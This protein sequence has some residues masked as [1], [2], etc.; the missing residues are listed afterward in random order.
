MEFILSTAIFYY[1]LITA[2]LIITLLSA[3]HALLYKRDPRAS[4]GWLAVIFMFPVFGYILYFLFG[5]NRI[6]T[7]ARILTGKIPITGFL[8][9]EPVSETVRLPHSLAILPQGCAE[10]ATIADSITGIPLTSGNRIDIL[11]NGDNAYPLMLDAIENAERSLFLS[12]YIFKTDSTGREFIERLSKA[13]ERGVD[14]KVIIDGIGEYYSFPF[15]GRLLKKR[16]IEYARYIPPALF[17]PSIHINLR[18]H[19]KIL[20]AD[21]KIAFTGG[22]NIGSYNLVNDHDNRKKVIDVHFRIDGPVVLQIE[23][24]FIEDW[25]FITGQDIEAEPYEDAYKEG[26]RCRVISEGP[27]EDFNKLATIITGAISSA[28]KRIMIMT[29][30]FLPNREMISALQTASLK[31]VEVSILLPEKNN[32][33]YVHWATRNMLWELLIRGVKVYYEPPPFVHT[34]LFVVDDSYA[35]IGTANMDARSL[36]LNFELAVEVYDMA[37]TGKI[38]GH[39]IDRIK[40][41]REATLAEMDSRPLAVR[42]RDAIA[43]LFY[44]YL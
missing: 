14:V 15:A 5:I 3:W 39:I 17:P 25:K 35:M 10:I 21:S 23:K 27:D 24:V 30:Y 2:N 26:A 28:K 19:R 18:N 36:R 4:L 32:L 12:T 40:V 29:P 6:R 13:K 9:L 43:W 11:H 1:I 37:F 34:K 33:P 22:I 41:S 44:P 20:V 16:R 38:S 31:G 42:T 7:R 8:R